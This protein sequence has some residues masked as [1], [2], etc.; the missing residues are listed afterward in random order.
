MTP[1]PA[2]ADSVKIMAEVEGSAHYDT[3][4]CVYGVDIFTSPTSTSRLASTKSG[5]V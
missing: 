5:S 3:T 2:W 1:Q 4:T